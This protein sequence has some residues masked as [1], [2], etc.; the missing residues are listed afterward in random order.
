MGPVRAAGSA[1]TDM[2][3]GLGQESLAKLWFRPVVLRVRLWGWQH[4][5]IGSVEPRLRILVTLEISTS[6]AVVPL[7]GTTAWPKK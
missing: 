4:E 2:R 6:V 1:P 3:L 5:R 7:W